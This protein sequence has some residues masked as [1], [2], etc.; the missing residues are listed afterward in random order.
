M[1]RV[2]TAAAIADSLGPTR[3]DLDESGAPG[4]AS[5]TDAYAAGDSAAPGDHAG[6]ASHAGSSAAGGGSSA[7]VAMDLTGSGASG[8]SGPAATAAHATSASLT[9]AAAGASS[10]GASASAASSGAAAGFASR[11]ARAK[12]EEDK[13]ALHFRVIRNDGVRHNMIWLTQVRARDS[14]RGCGICCRWVGRHESK[15]VCCRHMHR[16]FQPTPRIPAAG[17]VCARL[18]S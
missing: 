2:P 5:R 13:G 7:A 15:E 6:F 8:E 9:G 3:M 1:D 10:S 16:W 11:D 14:G 17:R 18:V 12:G 4:A